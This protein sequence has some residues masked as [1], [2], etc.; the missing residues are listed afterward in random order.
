MK[1]IFLKIVNLFRKKL[2]NPI[3]QSRGNYVNGVDSPTVDS[4]LVRRAEIVSGTQISFDKE[5]IYNSPDSVGT[6]NITQNLDSG[7]IG[8]IQK[9][10]HNDSSEPTFP[11]EWVLIGGSSYSV[12]ELNIIFAEFV[13][14]SRIEYWFVQEG[15]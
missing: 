13:S 8:V 14:T 4:Q 10:Y 5:K 7:Q 11:A 12:N 6:G 1:K 2:A 9:I 3:L 15:V